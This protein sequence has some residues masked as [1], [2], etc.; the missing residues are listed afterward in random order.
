MRSRHL[1]VL[2]L[3]PLL[4]CDGVLTD[5]SVPGGDGADAGVGADVSVGA[6]DGASGACPYAVTTSQ[7]SAQWRR[8]GP[9]GGFAK[10]MLTLD[11]GSLLVGTGRERGAAGVNGRMGGLYRS[12]DRGLTFAPLLGLG[13][14][15]VTSLAAQGMTI[16]VSI[17]ADTRD[18]GSGSGVRVSRNGGSSFQD[19]SLGL[20]DGARVR[21]L[22]LG[23]GPEARVYALVDGVPDDPDVDFTSLYRRDANG[24]WQRLDATGLDPN[25]GGPVRAIAVDPSLPNRLYAADGARFYVSDDGGQSFTAASLAEVFTPNGLRAITGIHVHPSR[26]GTV[27]LS[28]QTD[29]L[30][31]SEDGG[32]SWRRIGATAGIGVS[33]V[34]FTDGRVY[35]A[36]LGQ[37]LLAGDGEDFSPI[38]ACLLD[39]VLTGVA[40]GADS[41]QYVHVGTFGGGVFSSR[42]SAQTFAPQWSGIDELLARVETT[43]G[44]GGEDTWLLSG[45]GLFRLAQSDMR[46]ER[47]GEQ[48]GTISYSDIAQ[49]PS[50]P[51]RVLL[52]THEDLYAGG[53]E[54]TGVLQ[55][56][57]E[58]RTTS[59]ASGIDARNLGALVFADLQHVFAYQ[60]RGFGDLPGEVWMGLSASQDGG[61]SFSGTLV[62]SYDTYPLHPYVFPA[63][64]LVSR[65]DGTVVAGILVDEG[66]GAFS[67]AVVET[68]DGINSRELWSDRDDPDPARHM[69]GVYVSADGWVYLAGWHRGAALWR[70]RAGDFEPFV[71]GLP[72][73]VTTVRDLAFGPDG[74]IAVATNRGVFVRRDA[75][76][77]TDHNGGMTAARSA[78]S[79]AFRSSPPQALIATTTEGAVIWRTLD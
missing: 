4:A 66:E 46:W 10:A 2:G 40:V 64:P 9:P 32:A 35:V 45:A 11:D 47:Y 72:A 15:T 17:V 24:G 73:D 38:G 26:E 14:A 71:D 29:G 22:Q 62:R 43:Q 53:G 54:G 56:S 16:Y 48:V 1:A 67:R 50:D 5:G 51:D 77:F 39:P 37:G 55:L 75:E 7:P 31:A 57:L 59:P 25:P 65:G 68:T 41:A 52:A 6:D 78:F 3:I 27:L 34:A 74:R 13:V 36:T 21:Q 69:N 63:S 58:R 42:D 19:E 20:H 28:T 18:G 30:F 23:P 60:L 12:T 79:V 44:P 49:D 33:G 76:A 61:R 70:G 8:T